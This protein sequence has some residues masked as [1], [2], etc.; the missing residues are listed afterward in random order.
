[1]KK[2][3]A[4][5][6]ALMQLDFT[7]FMSILELISNHKYIEYRQYVDIFIKAYYFSNE[8][9]EEWIVEQKNLEPV[10]YS[11]K[12]LTNLIQCV[13]VSDKRTR[14]KLLNLLGTTNTTATTTTTTS[15]PSYTAANTTL[16][17]GTTSATATAS[18]ISSS[19]TT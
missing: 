16:T 5:G 11:N 12:Q 8:Q 14:Q 2:C 3:S 6:R 10:Q 17:G 13:C 19:T 9:F 18:S 1:M 4:G 7:N 15:N